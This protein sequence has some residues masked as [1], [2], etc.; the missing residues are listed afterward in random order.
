MAQRHSQR[1]LFVADD[2]NVSQ[3]ISNTEREFLSL[4]EE[5]ESNLDEA[6]CALLAGEVGRLE[7]LTHRQ[8]ELRGALLAVIQVSGSAQT[9]VEYRSPVGCNAA[10]RAAAGRVLYLGQVQCA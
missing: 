9:S 2:A 7:Q 10:M 4:I 1:T 8:A 5:L 6:Q 3:Q